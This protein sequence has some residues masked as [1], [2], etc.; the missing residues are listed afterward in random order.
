[1]KMN[2]TNCKDT[3]EIQKAVS[4]YIR[5]VDVQTGHS[6]RPKFTVVF[7]TCKTGKAKARKH[8]EE[9]FN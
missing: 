3:G 2:C 1:M 7:C 5:Q 9:Q 4:N 6:D 8:A